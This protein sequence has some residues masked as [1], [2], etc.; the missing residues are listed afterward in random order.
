[1]IWLQTLLAECVLPQDTLEICS[2]SEIRKSVLT[3]KITSKQEKIG[4]K[5]KK[6]PDSIALK[7][8]TW[9]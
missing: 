3:P 5:R 6:K 2:D 1:M 8:E 7:M 4:L 9:V